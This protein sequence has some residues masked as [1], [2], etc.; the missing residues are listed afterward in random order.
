MTLYRATVDMRLPGQLCA[1]DEVVDLD[2][3]SAIGRRD[4]EGMVSRG[5]LLPVDPEP[6]PV[7]EQDPDSGAEERMSAPAPRKRGR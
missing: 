1:R 5:L 7:V 6:E 2:D 3:S 4:V